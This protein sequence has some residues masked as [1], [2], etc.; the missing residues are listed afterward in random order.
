[1]IIWQWLCF[2]PGLVLVASGGVRRDCGLALV[3][4]GC[5]LTLYRRLVN[6]GWG[7]VV[8]MPNPKD[9]WV[10]G[11][12]SLALG[13]SIICLIKQDR[14]QIIELSHIYLLIQD[15]M[16][17]WFWEFI[18]NQLQII[19]WRFYTTVL[20]V[21][22]AQRLGNKNHSNL[23]NSAHLDPWS[24][25]CKSEKITSADVVQSQTDP[26]PSGRVL[27]YKMYIFLACMLNVMN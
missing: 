19:D 4:G 12:P 14:H 3:N 7:Q 20:P 21:L 8:V 25:G 6:P 10:M 23:L 9:S 5:T 17:D 13:W 27:M 18:R 22:P 26:L 2:S 16:H 24:D 1:M 15:V 11:W